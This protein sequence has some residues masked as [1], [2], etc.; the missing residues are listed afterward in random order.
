MRSISGIAIRA[1][2]AEV[3]TDAPDTAA[4]PAVENTVAKAIPPGNQPT[5]R[6]AAS[7]NALVKPA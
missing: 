6:L 2:T 7:N 5:Q 4:K 3:A 1:N